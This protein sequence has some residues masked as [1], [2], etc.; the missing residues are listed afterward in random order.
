MS[1]GEA[2]ELIRMVNILH[3][4]D[5]VRNFA[6]QVFAAAKK[7]KKIDS[8]KSE[9]IIASCLFMSIRVNGEAC[10][11]RMIIAELSLNREEFSKCYKFIRRNISKKFKSRVK[12]ATASDFLSKWRRLL[13]MSRGEISRA[14]EIAEQ[15]R[16]HPKFVSRQTNTIAATAIYIACEEHGETRSYE[17]LSNVARLDSSTIRSTIKIYKA[18][19]V[20]TAPKLPLVCVKLEPTDASTVQ[21]K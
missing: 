18:F 19:C 12:T 4:T 7:L 16:N 13:G 2:S 10:T 1:N 14:E 20:P 15:L 17:V 9:D 8:Y 11:D 3:C 5:K 6:I 21:T